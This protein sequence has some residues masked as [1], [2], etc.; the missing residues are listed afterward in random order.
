M[1]MISIP[2]ALAVFGALATGPALAAALNGQVL[3][4]G[5]PIAN[6]TVTLWAASAGAPKQ[7][8]QGR[9][10]N[11]GRFMLNAAGAPGKDATLYLVAKGG[12]PAPARR[13]GTTP[14]SR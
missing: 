7:L 2:S 10:G 5:A 9:T 12:T 6:S 3:G 4:G 11:D 1:R 8:A 13:A 14:Q